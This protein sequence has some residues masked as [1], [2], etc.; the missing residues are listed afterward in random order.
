MSG[1]AWMPHIRVRPAPTTTNFSTRWPTSAPPTTCLPPPTSMPVM[2]SGF[3]PN[4]SADARRDHSRNCVKRLRGNADPLISAEGRRVPGL[5]CC[6]SLHAREVVVGLRNRPL[7]DGMAPRGGGAP[8]APVRLGGGG[9][10]GPCYPPPQPVERARG[11]DSFHDL[12]P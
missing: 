3:L 11:R 7:G 6:R 12:V 5:P 4:S 9:P 1:G 8:G 2:N 10:P